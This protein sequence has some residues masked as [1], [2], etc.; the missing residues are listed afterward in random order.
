MWMI[1]TR[2]RIH[3]FA[4]PNHPI[5]MP[6]TPYPSYLDADLQAALEREDYERAALIRDKIRAWPADLSVSPHG[7]VLMAPK[8]WFGDLFK[9]EPMGPSPTRK[10]EPVHPSNDPVDR[11]LEFQK[12]AKQEALAKALTRINELEQREVPIGEFRIHG[13][14]VI[15]HRSN[16]QGFFWK[17]KCVM[18]MD[19]NQWPPRFLFEDL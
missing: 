19:W 17:G 1:R 8:A 4:Y 10:P 9:V 12:R 3:T 11:S 16:R 6:R 18:T 15:D 7:K 13:F 14:S 5:Q 2:T